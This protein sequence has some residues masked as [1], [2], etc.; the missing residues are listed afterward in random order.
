MVC[1]INPVRVTSCSVSNMTSKL[2][3]VI[4]KDVVDGRIN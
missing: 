3:E 2:K 4:N 1:E